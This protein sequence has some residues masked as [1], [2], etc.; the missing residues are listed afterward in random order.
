M[1]KVVICQH[2]LLHYR[3]KFFD[4]LREECAKRDI[5]LIL[6]HGQAT[7]RELTK[8]D[9]G[10]LSWA[11]KVKNK[12]LALGRRDIIWQPLPVNKGEVDLIILM[13]ENRILSN[14]QVL[15]NSLWSDYKVAYWGHGANF[16]S[17]SP[18]GILER[19]KKLLIHA[20]DWWFAY[21]DVTVEIL[22]SQG[23]AS[24]QITCLNNAID[25]KEFASLIEGIDNSQVDN[26]LNE[27]GLSSSDHIAIYCGS[28]YP[29][30]KID[31]MI[32]AADQVKA[33]LPSFQLV[34]IGDGPSAKE[35]IEAAKTRNW[36]KWLGVRKGLEKAIVFK[37][38]DV[39]F[40]PGAV[41]LHVLDAFS[42]GT[43]MI[44]T[45]DAK[46]GPEIS[47]LK[48]GVNGMLVS[49]EPREY[50]NAVISL[51][52]D[53][54]LLNKISRNALD[55]AA[56]FSLDNMVVNFVNG[57]DRCLSGKLSITDNP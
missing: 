54:A 36:L 7:E 27:H 15:L 53:K 31:Y 17:D 30:K 1:K 3:V 5:E 52:K 12:I 11:L 4:K 48:D 41:G 43:P 22:R 35:I 6:V 16:Q 20:V 21:T 46:H 9:E 19:W 42:S 26:Y 32:S 49:G 13:Q 33:E 39:V 55:D 57:V 2:R 18:N 10:Y 40:N 34:V 23:Y 25:N 51:L 29:D 28:L 37:A 24:D 45:K 47:Y 50:A 56:F 14:Y 38:A 8:Q 44:T